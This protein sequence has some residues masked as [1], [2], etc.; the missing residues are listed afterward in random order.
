MYTFLENNL[1]L[2]LTPEEPYQYRSASATY[3][4]NGWRNERFAE[5]IQSA[6]ELFIGEKFKLV[7]AFIELGPEKTENYLFLYIN[8]FSHTDKKR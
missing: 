3:E 2:D 7:E 5:A 4:V 6:I 1:G 8:L